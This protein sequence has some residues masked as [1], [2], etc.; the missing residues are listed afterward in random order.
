MTASNSIF[1]DVTP[2]ILAE[3]RQRFG[4]TFCIHV[5][6]VNS[7]EPLTVSTKLQFVTS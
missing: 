4:K 3:T 5:L 7:S 2:C 6:A 1:C